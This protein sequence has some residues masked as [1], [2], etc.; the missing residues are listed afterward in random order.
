MSTAYNEV[1]N[2]FGANKFHS[3]LGSS[4]LYFATQVVVQFLVYTAFDLIELR[5]EKPTSV[6]SDTNLAVQAQKL[7]RIWKVWI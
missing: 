7:G 5:H 6:V 3:L 1:C 4:E 2:K